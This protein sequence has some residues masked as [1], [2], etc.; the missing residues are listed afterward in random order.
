MLWGSCLIIFANYDLISSTFKQTTMVKI[1]KYLVLLFDIGFVAIVT[2]IYIFHLKN[3]LFH[4]ICYGLQVFVIVVENI[5][6]IKKLNLSPRLYV[7]SFGYYIAGFILWNIDNQM[8]SY[9]KTYRAK[10]D[11]YIQISDQQPATKMFI[12]TIILKVI[13]SF[14]IF[15]KSFSEFH[16]LWHLGTGYGAYLTI[17]FLL[18]AYYENLLTKRLNVISSMDS[19]KGLDD[20]V[21]KKMKLQ[22]KKTRPVVTRMI[23]IIYDLNHDYIRTKSKNY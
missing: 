9:L 2:Y 14:F 3:P 6:I 12:G 1:Y 23:G 10:I 16:A 18:D 4:E 21:K 17:L 15:L 20:D 8:C 5:Y 7:I 11:D 22:S 13:N 19:F